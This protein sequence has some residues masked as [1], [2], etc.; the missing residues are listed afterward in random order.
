[1]RTQI[2]WTKRILSVKVLANFQTDAT[3]GYE[4]NE[5]DW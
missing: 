5:S 3:R 4:T 2:T 1:M